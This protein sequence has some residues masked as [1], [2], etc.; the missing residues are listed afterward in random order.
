MISVIILTQDDEERLVRSLAVLTP[1]AAHGVV[2]DVIVADRGSRDATREVAE[3]AGCT[4]IE[5]CS[6]I[7]AAITKGATLARKDWLLRLMPG[8]LVDDAVAEAMRR[9][10]I[11]AGRLGVLE[12]SAFLAVPATANALRKAVMALAFDLIGYSRP[13]DR[14]VLAPRAESHLLAA[15]AGRWRGLRMKERVVSSEWRVVQHSAL[16]SGQR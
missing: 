3:A 7:G 10:V 5:D 9:H 2:A 6:D 8:D 4:I 14:R 16:R 13:L 1:L 15:A 12:P 11:Q